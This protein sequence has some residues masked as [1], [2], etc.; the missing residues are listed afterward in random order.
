MVR[1]YGPHRIAGPSSCSRTESVVQIWT[2][3]N[4]KPKKAPR[5]LPRL[6]MALVADAWAL[7]GR[8]CLLAR[9]SIAFIL[10]TPNACRRGLVRSVRVRVH[11]RRRSRDPRTRTSHGLGLNGQSGSTDCP[12]KPSP[13]HGLGLVRVRVWH[14]PR[15]RPINRSLVPVAKPLGHDRCGWC[16]K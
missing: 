14:C 15:L 8:S 9:Y 4:P 10:P 5:R 2:S 3:G 7:L 6:R 16:R 12:F 1:A 13:C 11:G